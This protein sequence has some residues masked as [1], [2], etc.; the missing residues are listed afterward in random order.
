MIDL[1]LNQKILF[2]FFDLV[3]RADKSLLIS[4]RTESYCV[5]VSKKGI[6]PNVIYNIKG[7]AFT[8]EL[9]NFSK[10]G[11]EGNQ[12]PFIIIGAEN[13]EACSR[14]MESGYQIIDYWLAMH[15]HLDKNFYYSSNNNSLKFSVQSVVMDD[16][17]DWN[18]FV[19]RELF[20]NRKLD[21]KIFEYLIKSGMEVVTLMMFDK[22][23]GSAL[24]YY[25]NDKLGSLFMVAIDKNLQGKG[26]G[27][28]LVNYSLDLMKKRKLESCLLQSTRP[29]I[30]LYRSLGFIEDG[31]YYWMFKTK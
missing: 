28:L 1:E 12:G 7:K 8:P 24:I 15:I 31:K 20:S 6:W 22:I 18:D 27:K 3:G 30:P 19:S 21:V 25:N 13:N 9:E 14:L 5:S 10:I 2:D 29:G 17:E 26:L 16:L 4:T 23:I 11:M